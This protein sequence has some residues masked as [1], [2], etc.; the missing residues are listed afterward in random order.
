MKLHFMSFILPRCVTFYLLKHR[1]YVVF[2]CNSWRGTPCSEIITRQNRNRQQERSAIDLVT[3][4]YI[5]G[6]WIENFKIDKVWDYRMRGKKESNHNSITVKLSLERGADYMAPKKVS[7]NLK[8][9]E[10]R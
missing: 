1:R 7:W 9:S 3:T 5:A 10:E 8:A 6:E 2:F 4:S